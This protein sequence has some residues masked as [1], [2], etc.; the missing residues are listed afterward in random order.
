MFCNIVFALVLS[1]VI[2]GCGPVQ[3]MTPKSEKDIVDDAVLVI[4][5]VKPERPDDKVFHTAEEFLDDSDLYIYCIE[6]TNWYNE[7][8][9]EDFNY[10][11]IQFHDNSEIH[12]VIGVLKYH[13]LFEA[14][15][16][17]FGNG[18]MIQPKE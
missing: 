5:N 16:S 9:E 17:P 14:V 1:I 12:R 11:I 2:V 13:N 6:Y 18:V 7:Y 10:I 4:P 15:L 8:K 3:Q